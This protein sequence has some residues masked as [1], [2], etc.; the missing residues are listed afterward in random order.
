MALLGSISRLG[1]NEAIE[2]ERGIDEE[3]KMESGTEKVLY[4]R[5]FVQNAQTHTHTHLPRQKHDGAELLNQQTKS[6]LRII[7]HLTKNCSDISV[8]NDEFYVP[9]L[10]GNLCRIG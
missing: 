9:I 6:V 8:L 10:W 2:E 4:Q 5:S 7:L 1:K 3:R